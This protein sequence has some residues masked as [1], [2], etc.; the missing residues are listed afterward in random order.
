M[1]LNDVAAEVAGLRIR[2]SQTLQKLGRLADA[3]RDVNEATNQNNLSNDDRLRA[4]RVLSRLSK[5]DNLDGANREECR[6]R[7]IDQLMYLHKA[8]FFRSAGP[9][10]IL[11]ESEDLAAVRDVSDVQAIMMAISK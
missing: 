2:R 4:A 8:G 9:A 7:A 1:A 6:R 3:L 5:A 10:K 11:K